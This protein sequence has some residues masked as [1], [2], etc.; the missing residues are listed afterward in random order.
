MIVTFGDKNLSIFIALR[1]LLILDI[2]A[3]FVLTT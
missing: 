2:A 1:F 3:V